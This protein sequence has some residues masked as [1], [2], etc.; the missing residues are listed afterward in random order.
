MNI[1]TKSIIDLDFLRKSI[2]DL[3]FSVVI[4]SGK[5]T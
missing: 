1:P 4:P 5:L 2:I 3:D